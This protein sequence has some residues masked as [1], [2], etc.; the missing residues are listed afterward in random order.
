MRQRSNVSLKFVGCGD[1][2][3]YKANFSI[4]FGLSQLVHDH[5]LLVEMCEEIIAGELDDD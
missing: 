3:I 5:K 1:L 4:T 2:Y